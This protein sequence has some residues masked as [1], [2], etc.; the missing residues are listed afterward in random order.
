MD[1]NKIYVVSKVGKACRV[2]GAKL[3]RDKQHRPIC[4]KCGVYHFTLEGCYMNK[5]MVKSSEILNNE[6]YAEVSEYIEECDKKADRLQKLC[7]GGK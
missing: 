4:S 1:K 2:C 7:E 5:K 3:T 6:R